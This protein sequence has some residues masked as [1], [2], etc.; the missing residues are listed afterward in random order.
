M[1]E[2]N[3]ANKRLAQID[4]LDAAL[5]NRLQD[6]LPLLP[7]PFAAIAAELGCSEDVVIDRLQRLLAQGTLTRFGPLFQIERAGGLFVLAAMQVPEQRFDAVAMLVNAL[8][9]VAH[10]YR[11]EH[12]LNMW[13]VI[14][15]ETPEQ[16]DSV[17]QRIEALTDCVV[18]A[19]PKERE[20]FVGLRLPAQANLVSGAA[21]GLESH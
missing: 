19:F 10:N 20:F 13:F 16:A 2:S 17:C 1:H 9:E 18:L 3:G 7:R 11:R 21:H 6:D 15:V 14:A 4:P 8:P 5:I 12:A